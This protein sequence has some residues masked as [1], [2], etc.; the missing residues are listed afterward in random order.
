MHHVKRLAMAIHSHRYGVTMLIYVLGAGLTGLACVVFARGFEWALSHRLDF[1]SV[2][3]WAWLLTP[4]GFL[5]AVEAI[6]RWAPFAA[7]TGIPQAV[8]GAEH[9]SN[10]T[11]VLIRPLFSWRTLAFKILTL[12]L[13]VWVGASTGREGPTVHVAVCVF[14]AWI[15]IARRWSGLPLDLRSAAVA[16]GA[17]GLAAAFNTPLAGVTFA[18][19]ELTKEGFGVIK[20]VVVMAIIGAAIIARVVTGEYNYF[21]R[22]PQPPGLKLSTIVLIGII[23]GGVGALFGWLLLRGSTWVRRLPP[24]QRRLATVAGALALL[25]FAWSAGLQVLGPGNR[26]A[27]ALLSGG[28]N[29]Q[30]FVYPWAKLA[31]TVLTYCSGMAGGIFAPCLSIGAALGA[32]LADLLRDPASSGALIGMAALLSGT[33]QA[34]ITSFVIIFEMTGH[35]DMLLPV[36]LSAMLA[37]MVSRLLGMPPLYHALSHGYRELLPPKAPQT[38]H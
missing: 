19:E 30:L 15:L 37:F 17:A 32:S 12:Y 29:S 35:H 27:Q 11:E 2:G 16:G 18:I 24:L 13:G 28:D 38:P 6:Q 25:A 23:G 9:F 3:V 8:F 31:A 34:P 10:R 1:A 20:D 26:V 33:I 5:I 4:V 36:M 14:V 22:L 21:G 7:G